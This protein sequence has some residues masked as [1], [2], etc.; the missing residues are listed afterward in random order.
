MAPITNGRLIFKEAPGPDEYPIPGKTTAYDESKTIDLEN[1]ALNGGFLVKVLVLS[2]DPFLRGRMSVPK[3]LEK[4]YPPALKPGEPLQNSGIGIVLRSEHTSVKQGDHVYGRISFEQYLIFPNLNGIEVLKN[5]ANIPI[6]NYLGVAGSPGLTAYAAWKEFIKPKGNEVVY[7]ST[8][9]GPVGST[10][11]QLAKRDGLKV[12]ASA[13]SDEKVK[14]MQEIGVD[15]PF[16][17]KTTDIKEILAKEGG[18]DIYWDNVGGETLDAAI[19]AS[20]PNARILACGMISGYNSPDSLAIK[21]IFQI[22]PKSI[23]IHGFNVPALAPK[24]IAEFRKEVPGLIAHGELKVLEHITKG[25]D[26]AGHALLDVL[27]GKNIGKSILIVAE[28]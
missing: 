27:T 14:F 19:D 9:A 22:I 15:V 5:E 3:G 26:K 16:N 18:I 28:A 21:N 7:V 24:Y 12:I 25:L 4:L 20:H 11:A 6:S 10:V 17:Y 13:G 8:G 2:I 1:V 23:T